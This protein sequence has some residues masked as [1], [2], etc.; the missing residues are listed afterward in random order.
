M[1]TLPYLI[2]K[3][4]DSPSIC[5]LMQLFSHET[6]EKIKFVRSKA[7]L[8]M[9]ETTVTQ[10]WLYDFK[11]FASYHPTRIIMSEAIDEK[12]NG[13]DIELAIQTSTGVILVP[14]QAKIIYN[15]KS[16]KSKVIR[17]EKYDQMQHGN[18]IYDLIDYA[19]RIKGFP[20]YLLY[21]YSYDSAFSAKSSGAHWG[22]TLI[23]AAYLLKKFTLPY[24]HVKTRELA[25]NI[26]HF[27]DLHPN[28]AVPWW[29][30]ACNLSSATTKK[31]LLTS[32]LPTFSNDINFIAETIQAYTLDEVI[33]DERW[34]PLIDDTQDNF[35][36]AGLAQLADDTK[37]RYRNNDY[38]PKFRILFLQPVLQPDSGLLP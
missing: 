21:N 7:G 8:K 25:W 11:L 6:W 28:P 15:H 22:C 5:T 10:N 3:F 18:Q 38:N 35:Q 13:N 23:S 19:K 32:L 27:K 31:D 16:L 4:N 14:L 9:F 26:P 34:K 12:T 30:F 1:F 17:A 29:I 2:S 33:S 24:S 37:N 36:P 20:M